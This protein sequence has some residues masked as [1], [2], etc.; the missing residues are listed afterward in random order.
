MENAKA[1]QVA[2]LKKPNLFPYIQ[3]LHLQKEILLTLKFHVE[4]N[5]D[6]NMENKWK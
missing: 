4:C 5:I 2:G 3:E 1:V 6:D